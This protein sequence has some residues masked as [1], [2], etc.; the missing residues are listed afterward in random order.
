MGE[1]WVLLI[2]PFKNLLTAYRMIL[3]AEGYQVETASD[4]DE[5]LDRF[6]ARRYSVILTEYFQPFGETARMIKWLK[7]K[8]PETYLM[9]VTEAIVDDHTYEKLFAIGVDDLI[10]KPSSPE[11][12]LAHMR[13]G[14]ERRDLMLK[15]QEL[16]ARSFLDPMTR[17][18]E[19]FV[20]NSSY[21]RKCF[22]QEVK[23]AKRHN[24]PLSILLVRIPSKEK[25]GDRFV[26][27]YQELAKILRGYVREE[28]FVG[29]ENGSFGVILPETDQPG[30]KV[31]LKRL[32][33]LIQNHPDFRSDELLKPIIKA[34]SVQSFTYPEEFAIPESLRAA[35][36]EDGKGHSR[37]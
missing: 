26:S 14:F 23:R 28:D 33:D 16:E 32:V 12:I 20:F 13:K 24:H 27:F 1:H 22:R 35:L 19:S 8:A 2:D 30:S 17:E 18:A 21:F 36:E 15:K 7:E 9:V 10:P 6:V 25:V 11:K 34:L 3:E 4:P 37:K 29:R 31:L 5:A